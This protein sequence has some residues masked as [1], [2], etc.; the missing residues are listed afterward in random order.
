MCNYPQARGFKV[1]EGNCFPLSCPSCWGV[2]VG[3]HLLPH[4]PT[5]SKPPTLHKMGRGQA[6]PSLPQDISGPVLAL[7]LVFIFSVFVSSP[8]LRRPGWRV[9]LPAIASSA[10]SRGNVTSHYPS[11]VPGVSFMQLVLKFCKLQFFFV[12]KMSQSICTDIVKCAGMFGKWVTYLSMIRSDPYLVTGCPPQS[13]G[14]RYTRS[15]KTY[16]SVLSI[17]KK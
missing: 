6:F 15:E 1:N 4:M 17:C 5:P 10:A 9:P 2:R 11:T 7:P 8:W 13:H 14:L 16:S 12:V 3:S